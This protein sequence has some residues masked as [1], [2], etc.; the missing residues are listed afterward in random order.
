MGPCGR[1]TVPCAQ[2]SCGRRGRR[3]SRPVGA[4]KGTSRLSRAAGSARALVSTFSCGPRGRGP[5][6]GTLWEG[7][8]PL[9][10]I[11]LR[12]AGTPSL[13]DLSGLARAPSHRVWF[14]VP[15]RRPWSAFPCGPPG[16]GPSRLGRFRTV[17]GTVAMAREGHDPPWPIFLRTVRTRSLPWEPCG[18]GTVPCARYCC[19]RRGRRP[20]PTWRGSQGHPAIGC[21]CRFGRG[22]LGLPFLADREDAVPPMR[23]CGRGTVLCA[24]YSCARRGTPSLPACRSSQGHPAIGCGFRFRRGARGLPFLAD[25]KDAVPPMG[26]CGRV[27]VPCAQYSCGRRGRRPSRAA[28]RRRGAFDL[29][30]PREG[31]SPLRP[32]FLLTARTRPLPGNDRGKGAVLCAR[33]SCGRRGQGPSRPVGVRKSTRPL[34]RLEGLVRPRCLPFLA[35]RGDAVPPKGPCGRGTVL[36]ARYS[37]G[38]RG[39]RPSPT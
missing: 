5:S 8:S 27:T 32:I 13:P 23:P 22:A 14:Q 33:Y 30:I 39:S 26:P 1:G 34:G 35:D 38:P 25:R 37:C 12:T 7:H 29:V 20:S 2:C 17:P 3:P 10:P 19:G 4:R 24:R 9:C 6:H 28:K 18:T 15:Q 11:S 31:R 21:G 36:C 16:C